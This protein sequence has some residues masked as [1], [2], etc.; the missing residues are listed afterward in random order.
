MSVRIG[1]VPVTANDNPTEVMYNNL[2]IAD[3]L[4]NL[5]LFLCARSAY[6]EIF[7]EKNYQDLEVYLR[8]NNFNIYLIARSVNLP[9][10]YQIKKFN[11]PNL[12]CEYECISSC[13]PHPYAMIELE[14]NWRSYNENF[15]ALKK[16]GDV[17]ISNESSL[18]GYNPEEDNIQIFKNNNEKK[19]MEFVSKNKVRIIFLPLKFDS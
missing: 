11:L 14:Q 18:D 16:A 12:R 13:R 7:P 15:E 9:F 4:L 5:K 8:H 6:F 3:S 17:C 10:E 2:R 1:L 19:M